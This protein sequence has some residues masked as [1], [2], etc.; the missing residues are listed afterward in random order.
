[1]FANFQFT[2][3]INYSRV[4]AFGFLNARTEGAPGNMGIYDQSLALNWIEDNIKSFGGDPNKLV[5]F[6]QSAG[7]ISIGIL[8]TY[9]KT[10]YLFSRAITQSGGFIIP[11][12]SKSY[13]NSFKFAR[14][15]GCLNEEIEKNQ[16]NYNSL[17]D[18]VVKCLKET[19]FEKLQNVRKS[20]IIYI[21]IQRL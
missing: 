13:E 10:K 5:P 11:Q 16:E 18:E 2:I 20:S 15:V 21:F 4:G 3:R 19:S 14:L 7:A 9:Y 17:P 6:G 1:L 8:M 12:F